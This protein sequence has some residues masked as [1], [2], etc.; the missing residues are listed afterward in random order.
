MSS[1]SPDLTDAR[2]REGILSMDDYVWLGSAFAVRRTISGIEEFADFARSLS[3]PVNTY[4]DW[5][6]AYWVASKPALRLG[7]IN[8]KLFAYRVHEAN[9]SG[10]VRTAS[11]A[12]RNFMRSCNTVEALVEIARRRGLP[13]KI[14]NSLQERAWSYRYLADLHRGLRLK[15]LRGFARAWPDFVRRK[16]IGKELLRL[17]GVQI[18]GPDRFSAMS[19]RRRILRGMPTS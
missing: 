17:A 3:D 9:H 10:D 11:R 13:Q 16:L 19:S 8:R 1:L 5:P 15:A 6:L 4:Q 14:V 12:A 2:L 7:W 18:L